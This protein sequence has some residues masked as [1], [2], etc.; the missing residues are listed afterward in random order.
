MCCATWSL[1]PSRLDRCLTP[2]PPVHDVLPLDV[3][4]GDDAWRRAPKH[5][6]RDVPAAWR[7]HS[8]P[9]TAS[10]SHPGGDTESDA[11]SSIVIQRRRSAAALH[12]RGRAMAATG[13][14]HWSAQ[15]RTVACPPHGTRCTRASSRQEND[16]TVLSAAALR[17]PTCVG[18][19]CWE[20]PA[21][22]HGL[23]HARA[24]AEAGKSP[25]SARLGD[26]AHTLMAPITPPLTLGARVGI[27]NGAPHFSALGQA[28]VVVAVPLCGRTLL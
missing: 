10:S 4:T 7:Q 2:P 28:S 19:K 23:I 22:V 3:C 17:T 6:P 18:D 26:D 1:H 25:A 24:C 12:P 20:A 8:P 9:G 11:P 21:V 13:P 15:S 14:A 27:R 16:N 5:V